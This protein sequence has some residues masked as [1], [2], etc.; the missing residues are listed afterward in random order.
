VIGREVYWLCRQMRSKSTFTNNRFEKVIH[1]RA[2]FR[3]MTTMTRLVARYV[4]P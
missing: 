4:T 2:T 3:S 1:G